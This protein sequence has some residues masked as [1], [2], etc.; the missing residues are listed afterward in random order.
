MKI[1]RKGWDKK[2]LLEYLN[3]QK[4]YDKN[5]SAKVLCQNEGCLF[6]TNVHECEISYELCEDE[7]GKMIPIPYFQIE[8]PICLDKITLIESDFE[9][10]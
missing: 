2:S 5:P 1:I 9:K 6:E 7:N 10:N 8:C 4:F 3:L